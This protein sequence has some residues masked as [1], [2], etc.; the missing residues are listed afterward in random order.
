MPMQQSLICNEVYSIK[1][2]IQAPY[3][4]ESDRAKKSSVKLEININHQYFF[5][6]GSNGKPWHQSPFSIIIVNFSWPRSAN[7]AKT[8]LKTEY[9]SVEISAVSKC[10]PSSKYAVEIV[11]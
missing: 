5:F 2:P 1:R 7:S 9:R 11:G 4:N 8:A 10:A 6:E 3:Y